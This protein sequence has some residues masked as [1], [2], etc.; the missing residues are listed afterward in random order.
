MLQKSGEINRIKMFPA[1]IIIQIMGSG[2][3][4]VVNPIK[5]SEL[6]TV[7]NQIKVSGLSTV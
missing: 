4:T 1:N 6:M 2:L 3:S 7:V 5:V